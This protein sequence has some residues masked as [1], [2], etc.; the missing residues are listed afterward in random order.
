MGEKTRALDL[1]TTSP[2]LIE[3]LRAE[4]A[5]LA[6]ETLARHNAALIDH[7]SH[8]RRGLEVLPT[9]HE[10]SKVT[11]LRRER[12]VVTARAAENDAIKRRNADLAR[13]KRAT[14]VTGP[15][16]EI[17]PTPIQRLAEMIEQAEAADR[18]FYEFEASY[19]DALEQHRIVAKR[20]DQFDLNV[21]RAEEQ[22]ERAPTFPALCAA[23][24]DVK[25]TRAVAEQ[26]KSELSDVRR[27]ADRLRELL[28]A[29]TQTANNLWRRVRSLIV[30]IRD[31]NSEE[32]TPGQMEI[33]TPHHRIN[34]VSGEVVRITDAVSA[35]PW[36]EDGEEDI[37]TQE[38]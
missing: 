38:M 16:P 25:E 28:E 15:V 10:G 20:V 31:G 37:L 17:V 21:R 7:R 23:Q 22:A 27:V 11:W 2:A 9:K 30:E 14:V 4:W 36:D 19:M 33:E 29:A 35:D 3:A 1:K 26:A 32:I 6:N 34:L 18:K 12:D 13:A 24:S 8:K 5:R